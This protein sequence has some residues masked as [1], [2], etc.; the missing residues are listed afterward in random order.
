MNSFKLT[1]RFFNLNL[2]YL[3]QLLSYHLQNNHFLD[4]N[5]RRRRNSVCIVVVYKTNP[6][7]H[8][9]FRLSNFHQP[10]FQE[11]RLLFLYLQSLWFLHRI[12]KFHRHR[13]SGEECLLFLGTVR[14]LLRSSS[15]FSWMWQN[16]YCCF[17]F[18]ESICNH[19]NECCRN[20]GLLRSI[21]GKK[22][23]WPHIEHSFRFELRKI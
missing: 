23:F 21:L 1:S 3:L 6:C 14:L 16:T 18:F 20:W 10:L 4:N 11:C 7:I 5:F 9:L 19:A 8:V 15:L 17:F 13:L 2:F 12:S 22:V